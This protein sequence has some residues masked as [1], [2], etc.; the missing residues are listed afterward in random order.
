M[1]KYFYRKR[2]NFVISKINNNIA[3]IKY[4]KI[5]PCAKQ[6]LKLVQ[7]SNKTGLPQGLNLYMCTGNV[8][9]NN[10]S[11]KGLT[12]EGKD[13]IERARKF[14]QE[15]HKSQLYGQGPVK[16]PYTYHPAGGAEL[17]ST[18]TDNPEVIAAAHLHD[19][20]EDTDATYEELCLKFGKKVADYVLSVTTDKKE[21]ERLGKAKALANEVKTIDENSLLI[22]LCD[23]KFNVDNLGDADADF[24]R[25]CALE[26]Y[27]IMKRLLEERPNIPA[28]CG[29]IIVNI[30]DTLENT[31]F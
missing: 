8:S 23:R 19:T 4:N 17:V 6:N 16:H 25:K 30:L 3:S 27:Y 7:N 31:I 28:P 24:R 13:L 5:K 18:Y 14:A 1:I 26:T 11:F 20:L 10:I 2:E 22:K 15:K 21:K 9:V 29:K 12:C